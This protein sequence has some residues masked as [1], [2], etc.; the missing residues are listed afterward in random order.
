MFSPSKV[1][2]KLESN[3]SEQNP[4]EQ[5]VSVTPHDEAGLVKQPVMY[6]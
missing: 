6:P 1:E 2:C 4:K 3:P 5:G